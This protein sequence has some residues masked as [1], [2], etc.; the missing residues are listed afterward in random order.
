[1][2]LSYLIIFTT[3]SGRGI[4]SYHC[5]KIQKN[6]QICIWL[7]YKTWKKKG[8]YFFCNFKKIRLFLF[9]KVKLWGTLLPTYFLSARYTKWKLMGLIKMFLRNEIIKLKSQC[10]LHLFSLG[11]WKFSKHFKMNTSVF[12]FYTFRSHV[13]TKPTSWSSQMVYFSNLATK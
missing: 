4:K 7:C 11:N 2:K 5:W 3:R 9:I 13:Y 8:W 1:M 12:C 10:A 6:C